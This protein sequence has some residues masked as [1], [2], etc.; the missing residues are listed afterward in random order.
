LPPGVATRECG[1]DPS[2]STKESAMTILDSPRFL[3]KVLLVDAAT[4]AAT[5]MLMLLGAASLA[6]LLGLPESLLRHAGA[7][8]LPFAALVAFLGSREHPPRP[9]VW[10]I[11]A[12]N[13]LWAIDSILVL[14]LGWASPSLPGK[15]F[16]VAQAAAVAVLAELQY[17]GLRRS[18]PA[19]A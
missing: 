11:V 13:A 19:I 3:N 7:S 16:V 17:F 1:V 18:R 4:S 15:L 8:L 14:L 2:T 5:G 9:A 6:P 10:A 12:C